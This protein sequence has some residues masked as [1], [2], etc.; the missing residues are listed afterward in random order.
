MFEALSN[1]TTNVL[2]HRVPR[3]MLRLIRISVLCRAQITLTIHHSFHHTR[4]R[5]KFF[6]G[7]ISRP[8]N[9]KSVFDRVIRQNTVQDFRQAKSSDIFLIRTGTLFGNSRAETCGF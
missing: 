7:V 8:L 9:R 3:I 1:N 2:Y 4:S 5:S 6:V